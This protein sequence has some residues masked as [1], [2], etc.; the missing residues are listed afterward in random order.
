MLGAILSARRLCRVADLARALL[1][2]APIVRPDRRAEKA[3]RAETPPGRL[4]SNPAKWCEGVRR[5][6]GGPQTPVIGPPSMGLSNLTL[7]SAHAARPL[8]QR[9]APS[10]LNRDVRQKARHDKGRGSAPEEVHFSRCGAGNSAG[11]G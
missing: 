5:L 11:E 7:Q 1:A 8:T 2:H 6:T 10:R 9:I 4:F 3:P